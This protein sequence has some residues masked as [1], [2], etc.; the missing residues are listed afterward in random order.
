MCDSNG[1][2]GKSIIEDGVKNLS[3]E[4]KVGNLYCL[5]DYGEMFKEKS[6]AEQFEL[7]ENISRLNSYIEMF[8]GQDEDK[9]FELMKQLAK[10]D[11]FKYMLCI[12]KGCAKTEYFTKDGLEYI[13]AFTY[14]ER[15]NREYCLPVIM[16]ADFAER[17]YM[18]NG[19]F[20]KIIRLNGHSNKNSELSPVM[21]Y[22][23]K[24]NVKVHRVYMKELGR[25][26]EG[27]QV[28]HLS[29][30]QG[31]IIKLMLRLCTNYQNQLNKVG[32]E[33]EGNSDYGYN[34]LQD[35]R[36]SFW[37]PFLHFM[38]GKATNVSFEDMTKLREM[39]IA[40]KRKKFGMCWL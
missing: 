30:C 20:D 19:E 4:K 27:L 18:K 17:H 14:A 33:I 36:C 16:D 6:E 22:N 13:L 31:L 32:V 40:I 15:K 25:D 39:E 28:D 5:N 11:G 21:D 23:G 1:C 12:G 3:G 7:V 9:Q 24:K 37:I 34:A 8:V 38:F 29:H 2:V 26:I 35:F 10:E